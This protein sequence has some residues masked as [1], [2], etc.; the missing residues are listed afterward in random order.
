MAGFRTTLCLVGNK[1]SQNLNLQGAGGMPPQSCVR[2][3]GHNATGKG[4]RGQY[5]FSTNEFHQGFRFFREK[6]F[7][8]SSTPRPCCGHVRRPKAPA[9]TMSGRTGCWGEVRS[10]ADPGGGHDACALRPLRGRWGCVLEGTPCSAH[11][12]PL[13]AA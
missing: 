4:L 8:G 1:C 9:A 3:G 6:I 7:Q 2:L 12:G 5:R 10:W 13:A 11:E